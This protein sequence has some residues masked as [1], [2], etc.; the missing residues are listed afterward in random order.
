[1]PSVPAS[2]APQ[3]IAGSCMRELSAARSLLGQVARD[4][5]ALDL[6][7]AFVDLRDARVAIMALDRI[8]LDIA[9]AAVDL[10]RLRAHPFGH[11]GGVELRL[12]RFREARHVGCAHARG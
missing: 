3:T 5:E 11:L 8:V 7:R 2:C 6:A 12:R 9:V 4:D 1:M 10:D